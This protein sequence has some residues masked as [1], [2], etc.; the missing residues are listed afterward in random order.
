MDN[1]KKLKTRKF[2]QMGQN[3]GREYTYNYCSR[4]GSPKEDDFDCYCKECR[5]ELNKKY[6]KENTK[7]HY[8]YKFINSNNEVLYTGSTA[9]KY[10]I[11]KHLSNGSNLKMSIY[12]WEKLNLD[13]IIYADV[14][15]LVKNKNEREYLEQLFIDQY[16]PCLNKKKASAILKLEKDRIGYLNDILKNIKFEEYNYKF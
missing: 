14:T 8:I 11:I 7:E 12:D 10:R 2:V 9:D 6:H 3:Q 4:C 5:S 13:K 16:N 15:T 1:N